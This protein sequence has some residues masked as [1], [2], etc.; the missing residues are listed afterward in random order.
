MI[1][2]KVIV[3]NEDGR[4]LKREVTRMTP[5]RLNLNANED[6]QNDLVMRNQGQ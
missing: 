2:V 5:Q 6:L 3:A 4:V 1:T